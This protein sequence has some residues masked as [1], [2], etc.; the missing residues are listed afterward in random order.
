VAPL[1]TEELVE[2]FYELFNPGEKEKGG[3]KSN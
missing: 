1:N 2:L 3:T